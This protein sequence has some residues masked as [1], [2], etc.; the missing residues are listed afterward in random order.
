MTQHEYFQQCILSLIW[1]KTYKVDPVLT[2]D[3]SVY[4]KAYETQWNE[5][6]S[7]ELKKVIIRLGGLYKSMVFLGLHEVLETIYWN[8]TVSHMLSCS[9]TSKAFWSHL[10]IPGVLYAIAVSNNY[11]CSTRVYKLPESKQHTSRITT[12]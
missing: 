10:I 4:Q 9:A 5:L 3:Q 6:E 8:H 1:Q 11:D 2:F 12:E 7:S